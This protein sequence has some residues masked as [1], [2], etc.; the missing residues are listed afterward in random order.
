MA[1]KPDALRAVSA[2]S[3]KRAFSSTSLAYGAI[4]FSESPRIAARSS[5]C[6]FVQCEEI[7]IRVSCHGNA[8]W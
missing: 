6:S 5:S 3:G 7:E 8:P 2:S 4:S 1:L